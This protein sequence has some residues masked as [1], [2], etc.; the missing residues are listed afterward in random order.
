MYTYS[1]IIPHKNIP[2]LLQRMLDSIP[3]RDDVQVIVVD[4]NSDPNIVDFLN[5]PGKTRANTDIIYT[6]E[7]KGAGYAR[8]IGMKRATGKWLIFADADDWFKESIGDVLDKYQKMSRDVVYFPFETNSNT[9]SDWITRAIGA[10][11]AYCDSMD[12]SVLMRHCTPF[13]KLFDREFIMNN[14]IEFSEVRWSNDM[15]FSCQALCKSRD[16]EIGDTVF[17]TY[18]CLRPGSLSNDTRIENRKEESIVRY[19][20]HEKCLFLLKKYGFE[21]DIIP[22]ALYRFNIVFHI[23]HLFALRSAV[24]LAFRGKMY[25]MLGY[26]FQRI[27]R[28]IRKLLRI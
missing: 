22:Q 23:D 28:K 14:G 25:N 11:S 2:E 9:P 15:W 13:A 5:F 26:C 1:I 12:K 19:I 24:R 17:Y 27:G 21:G 16:I 7:S 4:D 3:Q 20:E 6:K 10:C 18:D 8:N